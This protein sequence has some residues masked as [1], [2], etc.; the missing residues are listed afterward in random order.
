MISKLTREPITH[1]LKIFPEFFAAVCTGVKRAEL[2]KNDR[3]YRVGDTL[4][5]METPRGSCHRTGE[6][7]NVKITH[8]ADVGE[9]MPGYVLRSVELQELRKAD[10]EPVVWVSSESLDS[11][12]A[13]IEAVTIP[14]VPGM[15]IPLFRHPVVTHNGDCDTD[16]FGFARRSGGLVVI[17]VNGDPHIKD[18]MPL[19]RH[20]QPALVVPEALERLRTIVADPRRLPRRKEW[21]G[22]QQYSYVLLE[23]VEAIVE[24]ACRATML[25]AE[26]QNA[27]Q[28]IPEIIPEI[29]PGWILVS[30][31]IPDCWCRTCRPVAIN[32]MRFVVCPDCGNKRCPRA[33]DHRN[34]CAGSN[35]PGQEGSAYPSAP[36]EVK[37]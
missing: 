11:R 24:D 23:E 29:I 9:W 18:G 35:E 6:F 22:G 25:L 34:A 36:Q 21:I 30:E 13:G 19:Y 33:N 3:D 16:P 12:L 10:S 5:L 17:D 14:F 27:Q 8:I 2:R 26:P 31:R 7:I 4:H 20:A 32:D 28:N 37:P 1:E 15:D